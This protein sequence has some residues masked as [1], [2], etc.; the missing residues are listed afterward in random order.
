MRSSKVAVLSL[1]SI[2]SMELGRFD[3]TIPTFNTDSQPMAE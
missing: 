2:S 3:I 1:G